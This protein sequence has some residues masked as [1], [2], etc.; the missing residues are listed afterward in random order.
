[1]SGI[2]FT[3]DLHASKLVYN[4]H[5]SMRGDSLFAFKQITDFARSNNCLLT[6]LGDNFDKRYPDAE[7]VSWFLNSIA[8]INLAYIVGQHDMQMDV[9]WPSIVNTPKVL[10]CHLAQ[11]QEP[12]VYD[13][14]SIFGFDWHPRSEI[15]TLLKSVPENVDI[16]CVHQLFPEVMG[17]EGQWSMRLDW[18]NARDSGGPK[19][20]L[21][22]DYHGLPQ[23]GITEGRYWM[24]TGSSSLRSISEPPTKSFVHAQI[25]ASGKLVFSR[26]KLKTRPFIAMEVFNASDL[27]DSNV[28]AKL[29]QTVK[30]LY[31]QAIE[32][33]GIPEEVAEP[34]IS[35]KYDVS[36]SNVHTLIS[37][38]VNSIDKDVKFHL[39]LTPVRNNVDIEIT[40]PDAKETV[41]VETLIDAIVDKE[42]SPK[43]H[44]LVSRLA[45]SNISPRE[46]IT[47][48]KAE[49]GI[50][51]D[52]TL[53]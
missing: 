41:S 50:T 46:I 38:V 3:G 16:L 19:Y 8:D 37:E 39:H 17:L 9:Q 33:F 30:T 26:H 25:D 22:G 18:V 15:E 48:L 7:V 27:S 1:M 24:Y 51:D 45:L 43:L 5:P 36:I 35:V 2:V 10:R 29:P 31:S 44:S 20:I 40:I 23:E 4:R 49:Y 34:F 42:I 32:E 6:L 11:R 28:L 52:P 12:L 14:I 53:V 21:A 13:G 47:A